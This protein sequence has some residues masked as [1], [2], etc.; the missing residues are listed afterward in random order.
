MKKNKLTNLLKAGILFFGI[1]MLLWNCENNYVENSPTNIA[2]KVKNKV[3]LNDIN[4]EFYAKNNISINWNDYQTF[5]KNNITFYQFKI[6][7][8]NP[9]ISNDTTIFKSTPE[10]SLIVYQTAEGLSINITEIRPYHYDT[11]INSNIENLSEF[12]G[13]IRY[14]DKLGNLKNKEAYYNGQ[15]IKSDIEEF[16]PFPKKEFSKKENDYLARVQSCISTPSVT[17]IYSTTHH[18]MDYHTLTFSLSGGFMMNP[19]PYKTVYLGSTTETYTYTN[20]SCDTPHTGDEVYK[21]EYMREQKLIDIEDY[22]IDN[23]LQGI[24]KCVYE[25]MKKLYLFK[26][27]I[28]KFENSED[29]NLI[30][31]SWTKDACNNSSDDGCTDASDLSNGNIT[32]YIQNTGRG[33]LDL[34]AIILHEGIHAEIFKYVDQYKKGL[35]PNNRSNLLAYYFQYKAQNDNTLLTSTAQHQ[36]MADKYVKPIAYALRELDNYKY[37]PNEY[38]GL[39]WDGLRRYGWDGYYDKGKWVTLD[40]NQYTGNIKKVLDNT[41]FNKNCN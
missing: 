6:D 40:R 29:Y 11:S 13:S 28:K 41:D 20:Y 26:N 25:K 36:H 2:E 30:L 3:N 8:I 4:D 31:K 32:I 16:L 5:E 35:D 18:Y 39:A 23:E 34:A 19:V 9:L 14:F 22:K 38:M 7:F 17:H 37:G 12:S 15:L 27:T 33:T 21:S 24:A 1:S 10:L